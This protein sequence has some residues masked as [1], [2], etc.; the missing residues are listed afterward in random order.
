ML[1]L[2]FRHASIRS[3]EVANF[4]LGRHLLRE[5]LTASI[6]G[7]SIGSAIFVMSWIITGEPALS[8]GGVK[9]SGDW[10][11]LIPYVDIAA[12]RRQYSQRLLP[13]VLWLTPEQSGAYVRDWDPIW[14]PPEKSRAYAVQWFSFAGVALIMFVVLFH[15]SHPIT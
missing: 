3:G 12:L 11:E 7:I 13:M 2:S 9:L 14:L 8:L 4:R 10:P 1:V 6:T 5:M 15:F